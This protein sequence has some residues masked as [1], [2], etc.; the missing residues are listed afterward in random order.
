MLKVDNENKNTPNRPFST[1]D[2][3]SSLGNNI[4]KP[5]DIT[6][7]MWVPISVGTPKKAA[8]HSGNL[9]DRQKPVGN[10]KQAQNGKTSS[11]KKRPPQNAAAKKKHPP[12]SLNPERKK[13]PPENKTR[14][15]SHTEQRPQ[16]AKSQGE[17]ARNAAWQKK[18]KIEE[19]REKK[20]NENERR[21]YEKASESYN[22]QRKQGSSREE[23][24]KR[25]AKKKRRSK[26]FYAVTITAATLFVAVIA[27]LIYCFAIG[28]PVKTIIAD[29][30]SVY[31][32]EEIVSACGIVSGENIFTVSEKKVNTILTSALPYI[33]SVELKREFPDKLTLTVTATSEKYLIP[34][35]NGY[36]CLDKNEKVLSVKKQ[37][38]KTGVYRL[39]GFKGQSVKTGTVYE[40]CKEDQKRFENAKTVIAALENEGLKNANVLKLDSTDNIIVVYDGR[41]NIY[42][43]S[44]DNIE[45]KISLAARVIN[46]SV[47]KTNTGYIDV[48]YDSRAY[49]SEGNMEQQ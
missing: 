15:Q 28:S 37:K 39:D 26:R 11:Q 33:G 48:R 1:F 44:V 27:T 18:R 25:R 7:D 41:F 32:S 42:I 49:F 4:S 45:K 47:T 3:E 31:S 23:I 34:N 16:Y 35:S 43:G 13:R 29:G 30:K 10:R 6:S 14:Q 8:S 21:R 12:Q 40:P 24:S 9:S 2:F 22:R 46:E 38:L 17:E 19:Q 36:I 20:Q 5:K